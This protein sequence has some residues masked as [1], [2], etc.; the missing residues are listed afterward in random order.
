MGTR[1]CTASFRPIMHGPGGDW[2]AVLGLSSHCTVIGA[3]VRASFLVSPCLHAVGL[4]NIG[5][6]WQRCRGGQ[7][8]TLVA[9]QRHKCYTH[10]PT[11]SSSPHIPP[12][13]RLSDD[14]LL[15][16][17]LLCMGQEEIGTQCS[18]YHHTIQSSALQSELAS[19]SRHA[20]MPWALGILECSGNGVVVVVRA[21]AVRFRPEEIVR[22]G[23]LA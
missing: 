2:D 10:T 16:S 18:A 19:W 4:G 14:A 22:G 12:T 17:D 23:G 1:R 13:T 6:L 21:M 8:A 5:M 7:P 15:A 9:S 11:S 20:F 3:T